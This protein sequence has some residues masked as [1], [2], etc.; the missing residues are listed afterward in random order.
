[1]IVMRD[2]RSWSPMLAM[3]IPSMKIFPFTASKIL[4]IASASEDFPAPVRPTIPTWKRGL[5]QN[6]C[7]T[8]LDKWGY[9]SGPDSD[10]GWRQLAFIIQGNSPSLFHE[11][12]GKCPSRPTRD[13]CGTATHS[14][15]T[16]KC[17]SGARIGAKNCPLDSNWPKWDKQ[18]LVSREKK[19][20][21]LI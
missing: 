8:K 20:Y 15:E 16:P 1:M 14:P 18:Q 6:C 9:S 13:L 12:S 4:K 17:L 2:L 11:H 7:L 10:W 19:A 5:I 3:S 21:R